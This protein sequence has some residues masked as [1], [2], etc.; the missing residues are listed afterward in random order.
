MGCG[1]VRSHSASVSADIVCG[2]CVAVHCLCCIN[3]F[4]VL[5]VVSCD[6]LAPPPDGTLETTGRV[7]GSHA[8]YTCDEGFTLQGDMER[9]CD[10][11]GTW[12]GVAP[13]CL[14]ML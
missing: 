8:S 9:E 7:F 1:Q 13:I 4:L 11:S 5:I 10:S 3:S 2:L 14:G 6:L 12:T